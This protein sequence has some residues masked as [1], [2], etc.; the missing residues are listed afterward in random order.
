MSFSPWWKKEQ[1]RGRIE[2]K[3]KTACPLSCATF[4]HESLIHSLAA[5]LVRRL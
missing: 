3:N 4:S 1:L 2:I 5:Y